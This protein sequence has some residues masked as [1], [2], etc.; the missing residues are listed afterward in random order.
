MAW[1]T[2]AD[3]AD[4]KPADEA[5]IEAAAN[6]LDD[7]FER[8]MRP[9]SQGQGAPATPSDRPQGPTGT[10]DTAPVCAGNKT[11][12][13]LLDRVMGNV[14][15]PAVFGTPAD[16]AKLRSE[17][18][19]RIRTDEDAVN[20]AREAYKRAGDPYTRVLTEAD[21]R[22]ITRGSADNKEITTGV[23]FGFN[24]GAL[25][26]KDVRKDSPA[27]QAGLRAGDIVESINGK[28]SPATQPMDVA[29]AM[30]ETG[31]KTNELKIKRG[32]QTLNFNVKATEMESLAV[33][34]RMLPNGIAYI[35]LRTFMDSD[36]TDEMRRALE[37]HK[38]AKGF[39]IDV[40]NNG[41]GLFDPS[42]KIASLF[43]SEGALLNSSRRVADPKNPDAVNRS[44]RQYY[45]TDKGI[46][47]RSP[48]GK[49]VSNY[50]PRERD[51]VNQPV[52]VLINGRT[53]SSAEIFAGAMKDTGGATLIGTQSYGKGISQTI[54]KDGPAWTQITTMRYMTPSGHWLGDANKDKRGL[55]PTIK[56]DASNPTTGQDAQLDVA[57]R[58]LESLTSQQRR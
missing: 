20:F 7:V 40:R 50:A 32:D 41:G 13:T 57:R 29:R 55:V 4:S 16:R 24:N 37:R 45:L 53:G 38:D 34:D 44:E 26:I 12:E 18:N 52:V 42:M 30:D 49:T 36:V 33:S 21:Q 19:C 3:V 51:I 11:Y 35:R 56:V 5:A 31:N 28:S 39:I 2:E 15:D 58:Y 27:A 23:E 22:A 43:I 46:E 6:Q 47:L 1:E 9:R 17:F 25:I 8:I 54:Q 10:A 48:D 14:Y